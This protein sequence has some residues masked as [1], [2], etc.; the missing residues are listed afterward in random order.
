MAEGQGYSFKIS[1][2]NCDAFVTELSA[3]TGAKYY[4]DGNKNDEIDFN[5]LNNYTIFSGSSKKI[6]IC[7]RSNDFHDIEGKFTIWDGWRKVAE[8]SWKS[9]RATFSGRGNSSYSVDNINHEYYEVHHS[10]NGDQVDI[11]IT[12]TAKS[13]NPELVGKFKSWKIIS[14]EKIMESRLVKEIKDGKEIEITKKFEIGRE[15]NDKI[16]EESRNVLYHLRDNVYTGQSQKHLL[17][18]LRNE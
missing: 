6:N 7:G 5:A 18:A 1:P 4:S 13:V 17:R 10:S 12:R 11:S 9:E 2:N 3:I 16:W 8:V 15:F 14:Y